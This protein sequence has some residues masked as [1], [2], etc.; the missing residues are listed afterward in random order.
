MGFLLKAVNRLVN[1]TET[2]IAS[3][4]DEG[5]IK[6]GRKVICGTESG[7]MLLYSWGFFKDCRKKKKKKKKKEKKK[8]KITCIL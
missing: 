1:L 2:T 7:T 3:G 5:C 6:N 4:G 8:K